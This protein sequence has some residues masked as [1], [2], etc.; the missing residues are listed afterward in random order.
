MV[1]KS[2]Y[3]KKET[4]MRQVTPRGSQ[5]KLFT[6]YIYNFG[7]M[8]VDIIIIYQQYGKSKEI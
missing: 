4:I 6:K 2:N 8:K 3:R 1:Y 7:D 5:I